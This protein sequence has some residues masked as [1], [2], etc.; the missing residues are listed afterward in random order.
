MTESIVFDR[1]AALERVDGDVDLLR[2]LVAMCKHDF[3][4]K[5]P[6]LIRAVNGNDAAA[7][8][9]LAHSIKSAFGNLGA[10]RAF[11]AARDLE[12]AGR[13][14]DSKEFSGG[15]Q[16]LETECKRF[17]EFFETEFGAGK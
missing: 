16:R 8:K 4:V 7:V 3:S 6:A 9:E 15:V 17:I 11:E 10:T 1:V 13:E 5:L 2:E 12:K 14:G